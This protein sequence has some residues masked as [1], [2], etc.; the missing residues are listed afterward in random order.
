[1]ERLNVGTTAAD[2][3]QAYFFGAQP[4]A[5]VELY[6]PTKL[7]QWPGKFA[8]CAVTKATAN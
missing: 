7:P 3:D 5:L 8:A 1:L 6:P 4:V 2:G